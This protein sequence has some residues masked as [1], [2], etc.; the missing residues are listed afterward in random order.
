MTAVGRKPLD[1]AFA[2][3]EAPD[4]ARGTV[5][6]D[7]RRRRSAYRLVLSR[8]LL[9][10]PW[11]KGRHLGNVY[12]Q[13]EETKAEAEEKREIAR[14]E[15]VANAAYAADVGS[16]R[17]GPTNIPSSSTYTPPASKL[18]RPVAAPSIDSP[19]SHV[20]PPAQNKAPPKPTRR[21]HTSTAEVGIL[22]PGVQRWR[23][24]GRT[25]LS[26]APREE[27][28]GAV[29]AVHGD[30]K[31]EDGMEVDQKR[32]FHA[33]ADDDEGAGHRFKLRKKTAAV[34][35]GELYDPGPKATQAPK[36]TT[37]KWRK[38][39]EGPE[40]EAPVDAQAT[41]ASPPIKQAP[42]AD[43]SA[44]LIGDTTTVATGNGAVA[45]KQEETDTESDPGPPGAAGHEPPA[46]L[47]EKRKRLLLQWSTL[48]RS[49]NLV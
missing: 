4:R 39:G 45:V 40:S 9:P 30:V 14:I 18:A 8:H 32:P 13:R 47:I 23:G 25:S 22:Y 6:G 15:Q 29:K 46:G 11:N 2:Q 3:S 7:D 27:G 35:L 37:V 42:D 48:R 41:S 1:G 10:R 21:H 20:K 17:A 19:S 28:D 5:A 26:A 16:D 44:P 43:T 33:R 38:P 34:G 36:W 31:L 12:K 24:D 49:V